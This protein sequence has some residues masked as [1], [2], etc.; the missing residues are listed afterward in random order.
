MANSMELCKMLWADPCCHGNEIWHRRG[1]PVA[2]RLVLIYVWMYVCLGVSGMVQVSFASCWSLEVEVR[3]R[4][5]VYWRRNLL[6]FGSW[7]TCCILDTQSVLAMRWQQ[8]YLMCCCWL[9]L[10]LVLDCSSQLYPG[11][12]P[13]WKTGKVWEYDILVREKSEKLWKVRKKFG[14]LWFS[15][16]MLP[17]L[18]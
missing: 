2:Y 15:C 17:Q 12:A 4:L 16:G 10:V 11:W 5:A 18:Q 3:E 13:P 8:Y 9:V 1:D 6:K 7:K 14:N